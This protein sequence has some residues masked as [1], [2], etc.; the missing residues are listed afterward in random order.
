MSKIPI[1]VDYKPEYAIKCIIC[2]ET[3]QEVDSYKQIVP[4]VCQKCRHAVMLARFKWERE[5]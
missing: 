1:N 5:L 4:C 3:I 2:N